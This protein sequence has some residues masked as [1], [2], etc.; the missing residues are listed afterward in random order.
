MTAQKL[1]FDHAKRYPWR[2]LAAIG[3]DFSGAIFNGVGTTLI[4]PAVFELLGTGENTGAIAL[5][6][7]LARVIAP[8]WACRVQDGQ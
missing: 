5:P 6:P 8:W 1:L 7:L 3:L 2:V 4:V